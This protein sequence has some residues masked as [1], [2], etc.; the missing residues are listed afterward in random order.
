MVP[1]TQKLWKAKQ[2]SI[3]CDEKLKYWCSNREEMVCHSGHLNKHL[4]HSDKAITD[5]VAAI[6]IEVCFQPS[7]C[8]L[9]KEFLSNLDEKRIRTDTIAIE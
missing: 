6:K 5:I 8:F 4:G 1:I 3:H 7:I 2:C 9:K